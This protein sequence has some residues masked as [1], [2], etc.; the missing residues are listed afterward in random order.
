MVEIDNNIDEHVS[1]IKDNSVKW[2]EIE[3][4]MADYK[5]VIKMYEIAITENYKMTEKLQRTEKSHQ[6]TAHT[7]A[8]LKVTTWLTKLKKEHVDQVSMIN[9]LKAEHSQ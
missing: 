8:E 5:T 4:I 6:S 9:E 7:K 1:D 2:D 3:Q